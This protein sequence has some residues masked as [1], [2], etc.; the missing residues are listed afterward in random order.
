LVKRGKNQ[1]PSEYTKHVSAAS[2]GEDPS[3]PADI[4]ISKEQ[5]QANGTSIKGSFFCDADG[6]SDFD[7][8]FLKHRRPN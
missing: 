6:D 7:I 3:V 5:A 4:I 2:F 1:L 8:R